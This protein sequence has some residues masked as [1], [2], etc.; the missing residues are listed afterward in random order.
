MQGICTKQ[1]TPFLMKAKFGR[2]NLIIGKMNFV[3]GA[4]TAIK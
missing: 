1:F 4:R 3:S 2:E